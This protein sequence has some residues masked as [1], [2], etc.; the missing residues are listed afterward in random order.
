M[1]HIDF[2]H[3]ISILDKSQSIYVKH[4]NAC[5]KEVLDEL[6][7][8][9]DNINF[10]QVIVKPCQL[11]NQSDSPA[12][13]PPKLKKIMHLFRVIWIN[14]KYYNS[15]QT[16]TLLFQYLSNQI[17]S[18]CRSKI[19][20]IQILKGSPKLG[21]KMAN[22]SIDCCLSYRLIYDYVREYHKKRMHR[23][24]WDLDEPAIFNHV[25]AF[26]QRCEDFIEICN[27]MIVFGRCDETAAI[28]L[29]LFGGNRGPEF[30]QTCAFVESKFNK[31]LIDIQNASHHILDVHNNEWHNDV[32]KYNILIR[33]L[34]EIVKNLITNIFLSTSNVEEGVEA[35]CS[36]Y[37]FSSRPKLRPVYVQKTADMWQELI[38]EISITNKKLMEQV[39]EIPSWLPKISG[40]AVILKINLA[41]IVRLKKI[42]EHAEWLPECSTSAK[43][44]NQ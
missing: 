8:A 22:M 13:V 26:I 35:L 12:D 31:G 44:R 32:A 16:M 43:V 9:N 4:I 17:I 34:E 15:K 40:R 36:L 29:P 14:S 38:E 28:P 7:I 37:Y 18:I 42:F 39:S 25:N 23:Y 3:I 30:E 41:R 19:D 10:L 2:K 27:A 1:E 5:H 21:I 6:D 20:V 24:G 11:L 33:E